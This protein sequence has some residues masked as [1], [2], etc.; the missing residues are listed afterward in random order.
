MTDAEEIEL[1]EQ[2]IRDMQKQL[3]LSKERAA[4][5]GRATTSEDT[6]F[7]KLV[8]DE[9]RAGTPRAIAGQRVLLKYGVRPNASQVSKSRTAADDF[10]AEVDA[11]MIEKRLPRTTAMQEVRK[12]HPDLF[13]AYQEA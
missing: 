13:T 11:V 7:N 2:E 10:M 12:R 8:E 5:P 4:Y 1:L 3:A 6:D 9:I